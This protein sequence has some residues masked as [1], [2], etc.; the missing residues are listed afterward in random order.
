MKP[1]IQTQSQDSQNQGF[2]VTYSEDQL[3]HDILTLYVCQA[4][5]MGFMSDDTDPDSVVLGILKAQESKDSSLIFFP[6]ASVEEAGLNFDMIRETVFAK[7]I[8]DLYQFA[9]FGRVDLSEELLCFDGTVT[10]I[11]CIL[12][13]L[14]KSTYLEEWDANGGEGKDCAKRCFELALLANARKT[15]EDGEILF[16]AP[17]QTNDDYLTIK[18]LALLSGMEEMSIRAAANP[19]RASPLETMKY[20]DGSTVVSLEVAKKWLIEKK[21][22]VPITRF[23][24][25]GDSDITVRRYT[26]I[27]QLIEAMNVRLS[28][29]ISRSNDAEQVRNKL[30]E[31]QICFTTITP[32]TMVVHLDPVLIDFDDAEKNEK[33]AEILD[34]SSEVFKLRVKE[35]QLLEALAS[36]EQKLKP[37]ASS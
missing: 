16:D 12:H 25:R 17:G 6:D 22:Y 8:Y 36:I 9:Y 23:Y 26:S 35:A 19:K 14:Y 7:T 10:W 18:Q 5:V 34:V 32:S 28:F 13:D 2:P 4:R 21:R 24:G 11:C 31:L 20:S 1:Q 27:L 3:R 37:E 33:L 29:R 30:Q 15:L